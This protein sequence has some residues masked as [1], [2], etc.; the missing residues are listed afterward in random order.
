MCSSN[1]ETT[2]LTCLNGLETDSFT[3]TM[4]LIKPKLTSRQL[5][6]TIST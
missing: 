1:F 3:G 4:S 2:L 5:V 6:P